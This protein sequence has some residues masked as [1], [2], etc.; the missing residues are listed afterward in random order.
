MQD[1]IQLFVLSFECP[2]DSPQQDGFPYTSWKRMY[3]ILSFL[4]DSGIKFLRSLNDVE[5]H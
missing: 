3:I 4:M 2:L 1:I 5:F